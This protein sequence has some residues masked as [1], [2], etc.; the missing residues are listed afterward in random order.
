MIWHIVRFDFSHA[1]ETTRRDVEA[2]LAGLAAIEEVGFLRIGRDRDDDRVTGLV[3][4]FATAA[5][6]ETYK[7]HP[8]HLP[9]VETVRGLGLPVTR[10]DITTDDDVTDLLA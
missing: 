7:T 10:L 3:T 4:G 2:Q 1:S 8:D 5:D 9:V 6:L